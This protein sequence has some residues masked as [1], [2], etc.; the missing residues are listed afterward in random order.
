M[1]NCSEHQSSGRRCEDARDICRADDEAARAAVA[2]NQHQRRRCR[3]QPSLPA[4]Q[5]IPPLKL[6]RLDFREGCYQIN[7]RPNASFVTF[8]GTLRVDRS[9]PDGGADHLIVSGDL[10]SRPAGDRSDHAGAA[11]VAG[12]AQRRGRRRRRADP[13]GAHECRRCAERRRWAACPASDPQADDSDLPAFP[14]PF[15]SQGDERLGAGRG[16]AAREVRAHDHRRQFNYT[17]PPAG[18]FK[19]TF[20]SMPVAHRD[21][22]SSR[23]WRH[24]SRSP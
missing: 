13:V 14:L 8:E 1:C 12:V 24:R 17:Q 4:P 3:D 11:G 19:G 10:Y 15:V 22:E 23:K 20:P 21:V 5:P 7:F 9:A 16:L 18:Q 6:C 2:A